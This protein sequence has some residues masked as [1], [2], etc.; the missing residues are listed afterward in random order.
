MLT[1]QFDY[2]LRRRWL[3]KGRAA[4]GDPAATFQQHGATL[5]KN[6][7]RRLPIASVGEPNLHV[8]SDHPAEV[9][10]RLG[11]FLGPRRDAMI[12][13]DSL[14]FLLSCLVTTPRHLE[15]RILSL[16]NAV[17]HFEGTLQSLMDRMQRLDP[18][19]NDPRTYYGTIA[20][21][22]TQL[23][24]SN[25]RRDYGRDQ[26]GMMRFEIEAEG[27]MD[28]SLYLVVQGICD[29][30]DSNEK[31]RRRHGSA[32][33]RFLNWWHHRSTLR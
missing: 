24:I 31:S 33:L 29:D 7:Y 21:A 11:D 27:L 30:A 10:Y 22:T 32:R 25:I 12:S 14:Q 20:L 5:G 4:C 9:M 15:R 2:I 13:S 18:Q 26:E 8:L 3:S 17:A 19:S 16:H 23:F 28:G 1:Y 6:Y